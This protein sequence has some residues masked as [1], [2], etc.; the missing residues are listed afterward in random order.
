MNDKTLRDLRRPAGNADDKA[1]TITFPCDY[2]VKVVGDAAEDF[3]AM[4][5]QVVTRHAPD[6]DAAAVRVVPSRN[7]R[8]QSVRLTLRATGE[9]QLQALFADLKATGRVHMV[10]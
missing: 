7:G 4:V 8:F 3:T 1:P 9:E 5:C 2:P 6:F 10:V